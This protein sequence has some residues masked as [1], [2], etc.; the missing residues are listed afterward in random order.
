M[1]FTLSFVWRKFS[2]IKREGWCDVIKKMKEPKLGDAP[3][4]HPSI[5]QEDSSVKA[6][7]CPRHPLLHQQL[8]RSSLVKLYFNSVT[9]YPLYLKRLFVFLFAFVIFILWIKW[10]LAFLCGRETRSAFSYEYSYSS[11]IFV[12]YPSLA[13]V[14]FLALVFHAS[15]VE[16]VSFSYVTLSCFIVKYLE[17]LCLDKLIGVWLRTEN[18]KCGR[19]YDT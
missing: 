16:A 15:L 17:S 9:S 18:V 14:C 11:H 12:E 7:G 19:W 5:F 2:R 10:I 3:V 1:K 4:G 13:I 6:W 8:I